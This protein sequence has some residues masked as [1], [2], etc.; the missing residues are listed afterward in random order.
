M[1]NEDEAWMLS[2]RETVPSVLNRINQFL[3]WLVTRSENNI[4]VISHGVWIECCFHAHSPETLHESS[5]ASVD[6]VRNG[7]L[8]VG[9][10]VSLHGQFQRIEKVRRIE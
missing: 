7:D 1:T 4:V 3:Q 6:R 8:F 10:C 2:E 9:E 5:D